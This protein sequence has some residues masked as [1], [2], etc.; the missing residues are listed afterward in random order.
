MEVVSE[1]PW[2]TVVR[3]G[4]LFRKHCRASQRF[5][6]PL[7][8]ALASRWPDRVTELVEHGEDWFTMRDAGVPIA[9]VGD[10]ED[11]W[12]AALPLYA[13]LQRGETERAAEHLAAGVPDQRVD[14]LVERFETYPEFRAFAPRF[15]ELIG[16]LTVPATVQHDDLTAGNV[17]A[18]DGRVRILDWGDAV[19]GHPFASLVVTLRTYDGSAQPLRDAYLEPWGPGYGS[20]LDAALQVGAFTRI[21]SWQRIAS[22]TRDPR[23]YEAL[24]RNVEWFLENV[25]SS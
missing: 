11:A 3:D 5:E 10:Q 8:V 18:K 13:E 21:L 22:I 23:S 17:F 19:I 1:R 9:A 16:S 20:E 12:L 14:G 15:A 24:E 4:G 2:A 25:A 7:T 6:V